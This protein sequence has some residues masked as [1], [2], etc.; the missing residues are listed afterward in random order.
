VCVCVC[1]DCVDII[2][3]LCVCVCVKMN[4]FI[5]TKSVC[6]QRVCVCVVGR[7]LRPFECRKCPNQVYAP[8]PMNVQIFFW[9]KHSFRLP[10]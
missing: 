8:S 5:C 10:Y 9:P 3:T 4:V 1:R 2:S 6:A 7:D